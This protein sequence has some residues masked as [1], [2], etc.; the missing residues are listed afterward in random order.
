MNRNARRKHG[1][2]KYDRAGRIIDGLIDNGRLVLMIVFCLS[3]SFMTRALTDS[4][5]SVPDASPPVAENP[6]YEIPAQ[7]DDESSES[8]ARHRD[9]SEFRIKQFAECAD[10]SYR[11][12]NADECEGLN[13]YVDEALKK[14]IEKTIKDTSGPNDGGTYLDHDSLPIVVAIRTT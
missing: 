13:E 14:Y 7:P 11:E 2:Y 1:G 8:V 10:K 12:L 6:V 3:V 9:R 5:S 4:A